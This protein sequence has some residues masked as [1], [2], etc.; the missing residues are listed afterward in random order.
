M[1]Y[2]DIPPGTPSLSL[3]TVNSTAIQ[4]EPLQN[5]GDLDNTT[6]VFDVFRKQGS[7][8]QGFIFN[9]I[10]PAPHVDTTDLLPGTEY[11]YYAYA[12]YNGAQSQ[13]SAVVSQC[14]DP[15]M[16]LEVHVVN[17]TNDTVFLAWTSPNGGLTGSAI[18]VITYVYPLPYQTCCQ[19]KITSWR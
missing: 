8:E 3:S 2:V 17:S 16:P 5:M 7:M 15:E 11:S 12:F 10:P 18:V 14:T 13:I 1:L 4:V 6:V 19:L 9:D